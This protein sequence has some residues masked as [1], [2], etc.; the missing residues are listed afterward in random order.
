MS[1]FAV[2]S[3]VIYFMKMIFAVFQFKS[4]N[5]SNWHKWLYNKDLIFIFHD[6]ILIELYHSYYLLV[7]VNILSSSFDRC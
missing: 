4:N 2:H 7:V 5:T 3:I 1:H 6:H